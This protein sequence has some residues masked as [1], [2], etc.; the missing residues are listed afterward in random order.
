MDDSI[1]VL[2]CFMTQ[3]ADL[4]KGRSLICQF[5]VSNLAS[6]R[7]SNRER[8]QQFGN[9]WSPIGQET[10]STLVKR[11]SA[12]WSNHVNVCRTERFIYLEHVAV[13]TRIGRGVEDCDFLV[14][15]SSPR[16]ISYM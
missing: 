3:V 12:Y 4:Q 8:G 16:I 15:F 13:S 9:S 7:F 5:V 14:L 11:Q 6:Q 1:K 10:V 2:R